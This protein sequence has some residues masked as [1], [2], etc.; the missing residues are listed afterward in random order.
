M[1]GIFWTLFLIGLG[2]YLEAKYKP[3]L[4]HFNGALHFKYE[5]DKK[6]EFVKI[7]EL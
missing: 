2:I 6:E 5:V 1:S 3:R 4:K 7:I